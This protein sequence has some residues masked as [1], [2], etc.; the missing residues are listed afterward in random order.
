MNIL[1]RILGGKSS[2]REA[3]AATGATGEISRTIS[4]SETAESVDTPEI[5]GS[6]VEKRIFSLLNQ[7]EIEGWHPIASLAV[8]CNRC[9]QSISLDCEQPAVSEGVG[10][11]VGDA[12]RSLHDPLTCE[13]C[14]ATNFRI[15]NRRVSFEDWLRSCLDSTP[16]CGDDPEKGF[17]NSATGELVRDHHFKRAEDFAELWSQISPHLDESGTLKDNFTFNYMEIEGVGARRINRTTGVSHQNNMTQEFIVVIRDFNNTFWYRI[18][19]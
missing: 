2:E 11:R 19:K 7:A 3:K 1:K 8:V 14:G 13:A 6:E 9:N 15:V 18:E 10:F 5:S 12:F 4:E 16:A 17:R